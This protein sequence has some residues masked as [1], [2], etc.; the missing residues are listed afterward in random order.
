[1]LEV[2]GDKWNISLF[3]F[4]NHGASVGQALAGIEVPDAEMDEFIE[5]LER[6]G[7]LY[8]DE[9]EN[10]VYQIFLASRH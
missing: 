5:H 7:Y 2:L 1:F 9:T 6:L 3:H 4:R 8:T 10:P